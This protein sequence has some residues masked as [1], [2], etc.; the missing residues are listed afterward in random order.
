MDAL[1]DR[2]C[3]LSHLILFLRHGGDFIGYVFRGK[4]DVVHEC[5][6]SLAAA[7]GYHLEDSAI[8]RSGL[9]GPLPD[10]MDKITKKYGVYSSVWV[11]AYALRSFS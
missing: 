4:F 2:E 1:G 5:L 11:S 7:D 9:R 10:N 3:N 8:K 6:L